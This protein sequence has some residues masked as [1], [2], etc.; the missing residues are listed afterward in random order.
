LGTTSSGGILPLKSIGRQRTAAVQLGGRMPPL[1][2]RFLLGY[3][4]V[5]H[6]SHQL[7]HA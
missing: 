4:G 7:R 3:D 6:I 5:T 1:L 2:S